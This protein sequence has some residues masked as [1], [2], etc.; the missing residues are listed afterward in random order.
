MTNET[1][2]VDV[3]P[4]P[5]VYEHKQ[6]GWGDDLGPNFVYREDI[7]MFSPKTV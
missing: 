7:F 2:I 3:D 5:L 4:D 1:I 6:F